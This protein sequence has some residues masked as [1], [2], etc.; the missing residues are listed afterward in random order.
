MDLQALQQA[1]RSDHL[2]ARHQ[3][4]QRLY[5]LGVEYLRRAKQYDWDR[6]LLRNAAR[7]FSSAITHNRKAPE[8][9]LKQAFLFSLAGNTRKSLHY[10]RE[11]QRLNPEHP[12]L[13]RLLGYLQHKPQSLSSVS[14]A[15]SSPGAERT[16]RR[17]PRQAAPVDLQQLAYDRDKLAIELQQLMSKAYRELPALQPTWAQPVWKGYCRLR[18]EFDAKYHHLCDLLDRL[19]PHFDMTSMDLDLQ[20]LEI[21]LNRFD[22]V[23]EHSE[24]MV[25]LYQRIRHLETAF[26]R[27]LQRE[28]AGRAPAGE[29]DALLNKYQSLLDEMADELDIFEGSGMSIQQVLPRYESLVGMFQRLDAQVSGGQA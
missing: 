4:A 23:C 14:T 3:K 17:T 10:L 16:P 1:T 28:Q 19:S 13:K 21:S 7:C 2:H 29:S 8:P 24:Q 12:E 9:Y 15:T 22:D 20:K 26:E 18:D 6:V 11:A 25:Q 5:V 27:Q